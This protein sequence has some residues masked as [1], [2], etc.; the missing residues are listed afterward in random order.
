MITHLPWVETAS[1]LFLIRDLVPV[2]NLTLLPGCVDALRMR[3]SEASNG[4]MGIT[5]TY[6]IACWVQAVGE[7]T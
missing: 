7:G 5:W 2:S 6:H 4:V 3:V 1:R